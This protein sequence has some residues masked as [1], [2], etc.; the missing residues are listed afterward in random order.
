MSEKL[1]NS[2]QLPKNFKA[3]KKGFK[4]LV[5]LW[6][7]GRKFANSDIILDI[8]KT[9]YIDRNIMV[10]LCLIIGRWKI[11]NVH[12]VVDNCNVRYEVD[13]ECRI[14][15]ELIGKRKKDRDGIIT[16]RIVSYSADEKDKFRTDL[17]RY[18][19]QM[20]IEENY[21]PILQSRIS[22]L[23]INVKRHGRNEID[24][25]TKEVYF[26]YAQKA[27]QAIIAMV[28][29]GEFIQ[30]RI[31]GIVKIEYNSQWEYLKKALERGF[32]T[33]PKSENSGL[34]YY[35]INYDS[36]GTEICEGI[37]LPGEFP[38]TCIL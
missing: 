10:C 3:N 31:R 23:F 7:R 20:G 18:I 24:Y 26:G 25:G 22:E 5:N 33:K 28:N 15:E 34:G 32:S 37:D 1:K 8:S 21:S 27:H 17:R 35:S 6:Y 9:K 14:F 2:L 38:G 30:N 16:S 11:N 36:N 4:F 12:C 13:D 19:K 29:N